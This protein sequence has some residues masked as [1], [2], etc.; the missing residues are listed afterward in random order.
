M[1]KVVLLLMASALYF[2]GSAQTEEQLKELSVA[3]K[4]LASTDIVYPFIDTPAGYTGG[5]E[6]W[7]YYQMTSP[8]LKEAI[9]N[10]K[11]NNI[12]AGRYSIVVQFYIDTTGQVVNAKATGK[13]VGYGLDEAAVKFI[14]GSG[15]WLPANVEGEEVKSKVILPVNFSITYSK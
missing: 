3:R 12:P 15:K 1:K 13:P 5:N 6:R 4:A 8:V 14:E 9:K 2:T 7:L 10:A 11:E